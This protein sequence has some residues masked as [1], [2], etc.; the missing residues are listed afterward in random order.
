MSARR[1]NGDAA[2]EAAYRHCEAITRHEAANFYYGIRLLPPVKRRALCAIYALA[3]R[4]DDIGDGNQPD[5]EKLRLLEETHIAL[6]RLA[7]RST[8]PIFVALA[9]TSWRLPIPLD[10]FAD[11]LAG[12][13]MDVVGARY[14]RFADLELYCRRVAGSIGRLC[15]GVFGCSDLDAAMAL[16]D[17]LGVAMQL[18]NILRDVRE[19]AQNGRV[20]LPAE[21][22]ERFGWSNNGAGCSPAT[23]LSTAAGINGSAPPEIVDLVRFEAQRCRAWFDRGLELVPLLDRRSASCV[24]AM[25]G[26]YRRLLER[27]DAQPAE[28]LRQRLSLP[29]WEKAWVTARSAIGL[30]R[31]AI[32][33]AA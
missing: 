6:G 23:I 14:R 28:I 29:P 27:I 1:E 3:R 21:D 25:T 4:I 7:C 15:L 31:G 9:D 17:D 13:R 8:D 30:Q 24:L 32:G 12:V 5:A 18:T 16:A 19:D 20:Y 22:L 10:A 11:L 2:A 33:V 26:I